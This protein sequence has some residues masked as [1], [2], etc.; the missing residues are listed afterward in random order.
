MGRDKTLARILDKYYW[1]GVSSDVQQLCTACP[2]CQKGSQA[3]PRKTLQS[4][5]VISEPFSRIGM[6]LVGPLMRTKLNN[7]HILVVMD[8]TT[9][10]LEIYPL[11]TKES[12][13]ITD[14]LLVLFTRVGVPKEIVTDCGVNFLSRLMRELY[15]LLGVKSIHTN[16]YH[17]ETDGMVERFNQTLKT[18]LGSRPNYGTNIWLCLKYLVNTGNHTL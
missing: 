12:Q 13:A 3:R 8:Y 15:H 2:E 17:P 5:P 14:E 10:W 1:P 7:R 6:D 9:R 16:P 4:L 18:T 11:S